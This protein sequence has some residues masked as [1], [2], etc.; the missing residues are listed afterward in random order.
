MIALTLFSFY[1]Y[2]RIQQLL[3]YSVIIL[4]PIH[5]SLIPGTELH[6]MP[7]HDIIPHIK[8]LQLPPVP[9]LLN[10]NSRPF[11]L[12]FPQSLLI[13][14]FVTHQ[15]HHFATASQSSPHA[16]ASSHEL[17][18]FYELTSIP[19]EQVSFFFLTK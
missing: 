12:S 15:C 16:L 11:H 19:T 10:L 3:Q 9:L 18:T 4:I 2:L 6:D 17:L 14:Q 7:L 13:R 8:N 1:S 5:L